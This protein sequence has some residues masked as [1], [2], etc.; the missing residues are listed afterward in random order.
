MAKFPDGGSKPSPTGGGSNPPKSP[1]G[2]AP[3]ASFDVDHAND[4]VV[5][6]RAYLRFFRLA[7][8]QKIT[9]ARARVCV[10]VSV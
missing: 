2:A 4:S 9:S 1:R 5:R 3:D 7:R 8:E 10:Y 6:L